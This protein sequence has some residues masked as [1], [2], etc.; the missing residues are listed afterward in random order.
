VTRA[1]QKRKAGSSSTKTNQ[2]NSKE[3]RLEDR[4]PV[5]F[6]FFRLLVLYK[7]EIASL[8]STSFPPPLFWFTSEQRPHPF[9]ELLECGRIPLAQGDGKQEW[10]GGGLADGLH[11]L[12]R[13]DEEQGIVP[14][15]EEDVHV[16]GRGGAGPGSAVVGLG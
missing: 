10:S 9:H 8:L 2:C 6:V 1:K 11:Q 12:P 13:V 16:E 15:A 4:F 14:S 3:F 5:Q 7:W